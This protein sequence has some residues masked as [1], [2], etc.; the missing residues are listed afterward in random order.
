MTLLTSTMTLVF[1]IFVPVFWMVLWGS[2][3]LFS[4]MTADEDIPSSQPQLFRIFFTIT[5]LVGMLIIYWAFYPL[6]RVE[7]DGKYFYITNYFKTI[8]YFP[9]HTKIIRSR[10]RLGRI[11]I[12]IQFQDQTVFGKKICVMSNKGQFQLWTKILEQASSKND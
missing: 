12:Q 1:R 2:L 5:F 4:W 7:W 9:E 6:K 11:F 8:R 3:T 10:K